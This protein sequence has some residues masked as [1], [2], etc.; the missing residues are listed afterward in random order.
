MKRSTVTEGVRLRLLNSG[1]VV[2]LLFGVVACS[3]SRQLKPLASDAVV[4]AFGDSLT[5]GTG[6]GENGSYPYQLE[7]LIGRRV[8]NAGLSGEVSAAGV[9]RLP[10]LLEEYRP[11]LLILCHGGNDLLRRLDRQ[12]LRANLRRMIEAAQQAGAE[13]VLIAVPSPGL[14]I[15]APALYA[16]LAAEFDIP[17]L[18]ETL[19]ELQTERKFKSDA[20]HLNAAGYRQLAEGLK[21]LLKAT[22]A[23]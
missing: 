1:L 20:V 16:E 4:L 10:A 11:Q 13:V 5:W 9:E 6:G 18:G 19:V 2:L 14:L 12:A 8:I 17:L 3:N 15:G 21:E 23:I 7:Q 22:H